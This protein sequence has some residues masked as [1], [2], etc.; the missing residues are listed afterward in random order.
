MSS[1]GPTITNHPSD[2]S[3]IM[4]EVEVEEPKD[5]LKELSDS[6]NDSDDNKKTKIIAMTMMMRKN[7]KLS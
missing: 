5:I 1:S 6:D 2:S 3:S 4:A 7:K